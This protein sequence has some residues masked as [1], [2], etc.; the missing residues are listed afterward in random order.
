MGYVDF[1]GLRY[2]D[3]RD[4]E[5]VIFPLIPCGK[6]SLPSDSTARSDSI[7]LLAGDVDNAQDNKVELEVLQRHDRKL[8]ATVE[9]RRQ[10]GGKKFGNI[11]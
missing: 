5:N 6:K 10:I 4:L 11:F 2:Y 9:E 1:N 3:V 8:R 7:A